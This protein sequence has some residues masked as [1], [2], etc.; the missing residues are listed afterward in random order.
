MKRNPRT[1]VMRK[2]AEKIRLSNK[3]A[4]AQR[5]ERFEE[6]CSEMSIFELADTLNAEVNKMERDELKIGV[7]RRLI[8]DSGTLE[9][10]DY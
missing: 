4:R 9:P 7:L 6:E 2:S 10:E 1:P 5:I 8:R 3:E